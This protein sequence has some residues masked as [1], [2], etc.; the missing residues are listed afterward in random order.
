M[1]CDPLHGPLR[2]QLPSAAGSRVRITGLEG[3]AP[4]VPQDGRGMRFRLGCGHLLL[5]ED[6]RGGTTYQ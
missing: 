5:S 4:V 6:V 3:P 1:S 2:T